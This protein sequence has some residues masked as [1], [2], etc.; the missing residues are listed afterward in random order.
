MDTIRL[1]GEITPG[2]VKIVG[3]EVVRDRE[4]VM[5]QPEPG[6]FI[7]IRVP[8]GLRLEDFCRQEGV[9]VAEQIFSRTEQGGVAFRV[10]PRQVAEVVKRTCKREIAS[11]EAAVFL[12]LFHEELEGRLT[13]ALNGFVMAHFKGVGQ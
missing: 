9:Q 6:S 11:P 4:D 13:E 3:F 12:E 1:S 5:D 7:P 8:R 2:S 10:E